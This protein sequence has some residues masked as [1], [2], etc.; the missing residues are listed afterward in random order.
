MGKLKAK[1]LISF[2]ASEEEDEDKDRDIKAST[3]DR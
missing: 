1:Q 2:T 3:T